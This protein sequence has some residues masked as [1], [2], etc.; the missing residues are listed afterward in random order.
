MEV[1]NTANVN[2]Q[3]STSNTSGSNLAVEDFLQI[4]AAEIK[5]QSPMGGESGSGSKTDY[6]SQLAQFTMLEQMNTISDGINQ[7]SMLNQVSLIGKEVTIYNGEE[8]IK[9]VVEKVKFYNST[10]IL[11]VDNE[12]YPIGLLMEVSDGTSEEEVSE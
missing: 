7:L 1:Y 4:M 5:N 6:L 9:G 3:Y 2:Q 10:V 8:N 11:Q 12:D